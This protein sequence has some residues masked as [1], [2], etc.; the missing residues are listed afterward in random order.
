MKLDTESLNYINYDYDDVNLLVPSSP[1]T[2]S[3]FKFPALLTMALHFCFL[4]LREE[5]MVRTAKEKKTPPLTF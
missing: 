5:N 3:F 1:F 2:T 4:N